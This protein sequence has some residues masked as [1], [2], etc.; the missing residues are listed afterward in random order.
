MRGN[1]LLE[2]MME[3]GGS[4]AVEAKEGNNSMIGK[5]TMDYFSLIQGDDKESPEDMIDSVTVDGI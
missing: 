3:G 2:A 4:T 1:E 5:D